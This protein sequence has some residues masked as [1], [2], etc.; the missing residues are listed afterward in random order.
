MEVKKTQIKEGE[1]KLEAFGRMVELD[2]TCSESDRN[3]VLKLVSNELPK[4]YKVRCDTCKS[5]WARDPKSGRELMW[6][7]GGKFL[8]EIYRECIVCGKE[9]K[10]GDSCKHN[11]DGFLVHTACA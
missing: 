5:S 6:G 2:C 9:V 11:T 10:H 4:H 7:K 1:M 8:Y 3:T